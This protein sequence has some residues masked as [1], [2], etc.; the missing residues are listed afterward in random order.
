MYDAYSEAKNA[1]CH[2]VGERLADHGLLGPRDME[3]LL[4]VLLAPGVMLTA[5]RARPRQ[6]RLLLKP[7]AHRPFPGV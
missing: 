7:L 5:A 6:R 2:A 1:A 3:I 4:E